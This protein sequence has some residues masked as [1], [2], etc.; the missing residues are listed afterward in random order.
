MQ[1]KQLPSCTVRLSNGLVEQGGTR[2]VIGVA[3]TCIGV[4][5]GRTR[6]QH[7]LLF[8]WLQR[9][10]FVQQSHL[11]RRNGYRRW[12]AAMWRSVFETVS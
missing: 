7:T 12:S 3:T 4:S 2:M 1:L 6:P 5:C 10:S 11:T 9:S 8:I